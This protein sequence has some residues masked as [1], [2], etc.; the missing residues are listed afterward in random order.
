[1]VT[2]NPYLCFNG[3]TEEAFN[4]YRS[5]FGGDFARMSRF[6][7]MPSVAEKTEDMSEE[8]KKFC[9]ESAE[10]S[11]EDKEKIMH[12]ELPIG[13][14]LLMGSDMP[15]GKGEVKP[16]DSVSISIQAESEEEAER[17]FNGLAEGGKVTMPLRKAF[18]NAYF[19]TCVDRFGINWMV[20]YGY[21]QDKESNN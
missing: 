10:M 2:I 8:E 5:V 14:N 13:N 19:G 15:G 12:V 21:G 11:E 18:W 9:E 16:C 20:N 7:D 6:R 3:S 17:L 1:M 4:F